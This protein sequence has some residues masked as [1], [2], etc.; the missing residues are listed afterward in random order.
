[1]HLLSL[2]NI[3][4]ELEIISDI[5]LVLI[6]NTHKQVFSVNSFKNQDFSF[7]YTKSI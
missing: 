1:V 7:F 5:C 6:P 2:Q 4:Y 3:F